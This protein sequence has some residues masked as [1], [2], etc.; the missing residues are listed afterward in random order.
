[1]G[2]KQNIILT[3]F[4]GT[5]KTTVGRIVARSLGYGFMDTDVEIMAR[6]RCTIAEIFDTQGE[7]A[8]RRMEADLARELSHGEGM[9]ISTGGKMMLND[10]NKAVLE[11]SGV[12]FC[13]VADPGEIMARV[14][15]DTGV[16]RPLLRKSGGMETLLALLAER[17][18]GYGRYLQVDTMSKSPHEVAETIIE[19]F[20]THS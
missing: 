17:K 8:F 9:V 10:T 5:G 19:L 7:P 4:M 11:K 14:S 18:E 12:V 13:L 1:M 15:K 3:G 20:R 6:Q 2:K 16:E